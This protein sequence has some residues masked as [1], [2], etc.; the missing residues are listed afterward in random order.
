MLRYLL[1]TAGSLFLALGIIGIFVPLLPTTP[2]LLLAAACYLRSSPVL[3]HRL[4]NHRFLGLYLR[5]YRDG[6]GLP[7]HAR[8]ITI[9]LLWLTIGYSALFIIDSLHL[10]LFLLIIAI[11]VT[12]HVVSLRPKP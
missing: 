5:A 11:A 7:L 2:F 6:T 8:V 9:S 12:I 3:Y 4:Y 1:I 10:R